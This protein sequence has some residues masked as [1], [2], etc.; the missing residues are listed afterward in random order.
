M[1]YEVTPFNGTKLERFIYYRNRA[2][3]T[4][5][6]ARDFTDEA[7]Q[8]PLLDVAA[9]YDKLADLIEREI[10]SATAFSKPAT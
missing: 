1:D 5:I 9:A 7:R 3:E 8:K 10:N 2:E 6:L 4:R